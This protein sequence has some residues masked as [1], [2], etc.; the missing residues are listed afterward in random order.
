MELIE[1]TQF[2]ENEKYVKELDLFHEAQRKELDLYDKVLTTEEPAPIYDITIFK[3]YL[4]LAFTTSL[5]ER[6]YIVNGEEMTYSEITLA[7]GEIYLTKQPIEQT[8]EQ[9][10][11]AK[12]RRN[13]L[14]LQKPIP[15]PTKK[16]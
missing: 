7:S 13:T 6:T 9:V 4:D 11:K 12:K 5:D 3:K 14:F 1:I 8:H 16:D 10:E 2:I 15:R